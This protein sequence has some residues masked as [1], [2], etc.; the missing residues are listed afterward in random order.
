MSKKEVVTIEGKRPADATPEKALELS[1]N[2]TQEEIGKLW[3]ISRQR[4]SQLI[5]RAR[6]NLYRM[7]D[8]G[9]KTER[10]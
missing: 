8:A 9:I 1:K 7:K 2:L 3:G 6:Q 5:K 4:V 10:H